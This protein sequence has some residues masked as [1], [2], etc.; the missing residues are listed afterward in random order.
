[1]NQT[2]QDNNNTEALKL[3]LLDV[4]WQVTGIDRH[5][6]A[7]EN[8]QQ[9]EC[10]R[11]VVT[12]EK[13]AQVY[14]WTQDVV[15]L[16]PQD[17]YTVGD[18]LRLVVGLNEQYHQQYRHQS[19]QTPYTANK[20]G[21]PLFLAGLENIHAGIIEQVIQGEQHDIPV[22][23]ITISSSGHGTTLQLPANMHKNMID[24]LRPEMQVYIG[25]AR[26]N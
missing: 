20:A 15:V 14:Y 3:V 13:Y 22:L 12:E 24:T 26:M 18:R 6:G 11:L 25:T 21:P 10:R 23:Q 7:Q 9:L 5:S 19:G 4:E 16:C 2:S 17:Q 1:M 8:L